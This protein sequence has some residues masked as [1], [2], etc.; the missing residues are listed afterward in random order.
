MAL[1]LA[2]PQTDGQT[3]ILNATIEQMLHAYV[4]SN[5]ENWSSWLSVLTYS[6]NSSM[7]SS[8]KYSPNFLLMG[9]NPH[10]SM[11]VIIPEI[12]PALRRFLPSQS[13][14]DF[15]EAIEVHCNLAKDTIALTQD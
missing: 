11:S 9:Y 13:A 2:H 8:T 7:H 12:D 4:S 3:E 5:K 10:T 14:E 15:V 6:Y 1:S